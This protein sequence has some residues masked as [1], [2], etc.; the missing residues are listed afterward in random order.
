MT[1]AEILKELNF[2]LESRFRPSIK[3]QIVLI[4]VMRGSKIRN[5]EHK[6]ATLTYSILTIK[7]AIEDDTLID[8]VADDESTLNVPLTTFYRSEPK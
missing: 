4:D 5:N 8:L 2:V 6:I 3:N 7:Q 1:N